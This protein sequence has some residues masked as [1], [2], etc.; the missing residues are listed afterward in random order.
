MCYLLVV[1]NSFGIMCNTPLAWNNVMEEHVKKHVATFY[2]KP[3]RL[4]FLWKTTLKWYYNIVSHTLSNF[5]VHQRFYKYQDTGTRQWLN[6]TLCGNHLQ[7]AS[8]WGKDGSEHIQLVWV[9]LYLNKNLPPVQFYVDGLQKSIC[10]KFPP[11]KSVLLS[12]YI[13]KIKLP[14]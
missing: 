10:C 5:S 7:C 12:I 14:S 4:F 1:Q 9:Y 2:T 11:W 13:W 8:K 3:Y 6:F